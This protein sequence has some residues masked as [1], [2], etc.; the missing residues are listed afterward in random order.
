MKLAELLIERAECQNKIAEL[1]TQI[2]ANL[3]IQEGDKESVNVNDLLDEFSNINSRLA[4]LV[5]LINTTNSKIKLKNGNTLTEAIALR[6]SL[7]AKIDFYKEII[8]A[9]NARDYRITR[10]EIKMV[11]SLDINDI[12]KEIDALSKKFRLL[13]NEIQQVNWTVDI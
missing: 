12:L 10:S 7:R 8:K 6:D 13:D 2:V 3:K 5:I 4:Q 11:L 1:K 9:S